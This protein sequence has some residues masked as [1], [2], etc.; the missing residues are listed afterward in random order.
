MTFSEE[1]LMAYADNELD[2]QTRSA[3]EAAMATDPEV[4]RRVAQHKALRGQ[5]RLAYDKALDEP[6]PQRLVDAARGVPAVRR[7]GNVIPLRRK[8]PPRRTWPQWA[9]VA[10]SLVAGVLIGQAL[11]RTSNTGGPVTTSRDGQLLANGVLARALSDQLAGE[12]TQDTPVRIGVSFKSKSGDYCRTFALQEPAPLAGL[13][14]RE[15]DDWH[16][17]VLAQTT[18]TPPSGYRQAGS[19]IPRSVM[20]AVDDTIAGE[21]LDAHAEAAARDKNWSR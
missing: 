6:P 11:L 8:P 20:Q 12:Q 10:A 16:V 9:S 3:V 13:A 4:A 5:L 7:E 19:E 18:S 15:H 17:Q 21:P 2:S 14:C 1:T